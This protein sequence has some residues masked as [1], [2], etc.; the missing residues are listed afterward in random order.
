MDHDSKL[1]PVER[2][3]GGA[4]ESIPAQGPA[5]YAPWEQPARDTHLL[6]Y[7][8]ILR[9]HQ[10]LVLFFLLAV[11]S[12]VSVATFKMQPVYVATARIEI[13]REN[14]NILPFQS[15]SYELY[16]DLENYIET[17]ARI[18]QSETLAFLTI[19]SL[20][21]VRNPAFGGSPNASLPA[22][23]GSSTTTE[24]RPAILGAFL[25]SLSVKR[26]SNS[27]LLEVQFESPDPRLAARILNNH[28]ENYIEQN[29]R[30]KYEATTQASNWLARQL[31]ELK[32]R[33]E[34]SEDAR[35]LYERNN[36]IWTVD[37]KQDITTQKLSDLNKELTEAQAD[38][39]QKESQYQLARTGNLDAMPAVR[40][41]QAIQ[42]LLQ[43]ETELYAQYSEAL[44]QF[45]PK[46]PKVM[47]LET[48]V[49][50]LNALI[51]RE[52][53]N[54]VARIEL[55]FRAARQREA[56]LTQALEK[57]KQEANELAQKLVQYNILKREAET[58]KQL[59][60]GLLQKLK[61]ATISAGLRSSNVR[62]VDPALV[63]PSPAR[64]NKTRNILLAFLVGL[65]GGIGLA[66]LR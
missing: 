40:D 54:V 52:K 7:V 64:P 1:V 46:Y 60:E 35:L 41:S 58:N 42:E 14:P 48:Q 24:R 8:V 62:V 61:E 17:Q 43:R 47:R 53:Q 27:R 13:D 45:G 9:K 10:W 63:P 6:D 12:I 22:G 32:I 59:Y 37:E 19:K 66:F 34:K 21:L 33:V 65:V 5:P 23:L 31:D 50:D 15:S 25:G 20:D 36:E 55:E 3:A 16:W 30:S 29:F 56:L 26:V 49:R 28:L 4:L 11:V 44:A 38:R 18:L 2:K 39:I 57:Q 51:A